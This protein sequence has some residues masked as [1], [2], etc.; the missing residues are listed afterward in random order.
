MTFIAV[1]L[2]VAPAQASRA[3]TQQTGA[4]TVTTEATNPVTVRTTRVGT[5]EVWH[6]SGD[7]VILTLSVSDVR[8]GMTVSAEKIVEEPKVEISTNGKIVG[9]APWR[10]A[11]VHPVCCS[12]EAHRGAAHTG[13]DAPPIVGNPSRSPVKQDY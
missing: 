13:A 4:A 11:C 5:G 6:V 7:S 12:L 10:G 8:P 3:T 2:F 1:L 9:Q